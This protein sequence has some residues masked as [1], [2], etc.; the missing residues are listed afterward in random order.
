MT[1]V[2]VVVPNR[3]NGEAVPRRANHQVEDEKEE[4]AVVLHADAVVDPG[5]VVIHH[6]DTPIANSAM[7]RSGRLY[8]IA[9]LTLA[10]PVWPQLVHR[11]GAVAEGLLDLGRETSESVII[12]QISFLARLPL[13]KLEPQ[14]LNQLDFRGPVSEDK[15]SHGMVEHN[16]EAQ[17]RADHKP[18]HAKC[19]TKP[20]K[21]NLDDQA[22]KNVNVHVDQIVESANEEGPSDAK[23]EGAH[24]A[25]WFEE[26]A[27]SHSEHLLD[28][29]GSFAVARPYYVSHN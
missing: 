26:P 13:F 20:F 27:P 29:I 11:L 5:T 23:G 3:N 16:I 22:Q 25:D 17:N 15:R 28:A 4:V 18:E 24:E 7:M 12:L 19:D 2:N 14:F 21:Q 9:L 8:F 1:Y 6:E 10:F